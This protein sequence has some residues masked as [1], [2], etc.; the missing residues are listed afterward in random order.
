MDSPPGGAV[1][2]DPELCVD[3]GRPVPGGGFCRECLAARI[4]KLS[5]RY[6]AV[7]E[8]QERIEASGD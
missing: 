5:Q 6:D 1:S 8:E 3:C 4:R 7:L 2:R